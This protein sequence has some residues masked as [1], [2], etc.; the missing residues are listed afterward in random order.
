VD[1][2]ASPGF[3]GR[4]QLTRGQ[5]SSNSGPAKAPHLIR[6]SV[7]FYTVLFRVNEGNLVNVSPF[8][9][10]WTPTIRRII[11]DVAHRKPPHPIHDSTSLISHQSKH[12]WVGGFRPMCGTRGT[13][14]GWQIH[15]NTQCLRLP[16][17]GLNPIM[18]TQ[19]NR[20]NYRTGGSN[21]GGPSGSVDSV[22]EKAGNRRSIDG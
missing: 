13:V 16:R 8:L 2:V 20:L 17:S 3:C 14:F 7:L 12:H 4:F 9:G 19:P 21:V 11:P 18:H 1:W 5:L 15:S 6:L 22:V 10:T